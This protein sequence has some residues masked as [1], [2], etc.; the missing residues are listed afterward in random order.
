MKKLLYGLLSIILVSGGLVA[1]APGAAPTEAPYYQGKTIEIVASS[2]AGGG[3]D[4]VARITA[5]FLGKYIPG[6]PTIMVTNQPGGGGQIAHKVFTYNTNPDGLTL[7]Q[8][9][10]SS[11]SMQ[12]KQGASAAGYDI[13]KYKHIGNVIRSQSVLM[14]KKG[15][16]AR[17]TNPSAKPI[18]VGCKEGSETWMGMILWG[19]EFLGW[20][21]KIVPGYG[22]TSEIEMAFLRPGEVEMMA[23]SDAFIIRRMLEEGGAEVLCC[24]SPRPDFPDLPTFEELLGNKKP[25]GLPWQAYL[26][27]QGPDLADKYLSAPPGTP[28]DIVAILVEA[29]S[30][31]SQ[32]PEFD[33][34]MKKQVSESYSV[35]IGQETTNIINGLLSVTPEVQDYMKTLQ[36]KAGIIAK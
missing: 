22:G 34:M 31:M 29:F 18:M 28:D 17:L 11:I 30:Q 3:T 24:D 33:Q 6:N 1:C 13:T 10:T 27:W 12:M 2:A 26:A 20:N 23:T 4:M 25:T 14:I 32:D 8:S 15:Q 35:C 16:R 36:L 5:S 7:L 9:S 21:V 19:K